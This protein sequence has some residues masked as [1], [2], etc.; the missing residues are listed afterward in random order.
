MCLD[1]IVWKNRRRQPP[2]DLKHHRIIS[3]TFLFFPINISR[4][5]ASY[6]LRIHHS[7]LCCSKTINP[8]CIPEYFAEKEIT[9]RQQ[10]LAWVERIV[11]KSFGFSRVTST[12]A[13]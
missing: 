6:V 7:T 12:K 11:G 4:Q 9:Q 1:L 5:Y 3:L 2:F 10:S 13:G 8:G